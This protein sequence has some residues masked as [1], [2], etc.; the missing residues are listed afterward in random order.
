MRAPRRR[1][2]THSARQRFLCSLGRDVRAYAR[3]LR[4]L[5]SG[6]MYTPY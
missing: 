2:S 4:A 5:R 6:R 1:S 3:L